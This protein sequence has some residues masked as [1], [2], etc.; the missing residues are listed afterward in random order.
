VAVFLCGLQRAFNDFFC[1]ESCGYCTPCRVGNV[2]LSERLEKIVSIASA[3]VFMQGGTGTLLELALVLEGINKGADKPKPMI[4]LGDFWKP[5]VELVLANRPGK[6][7]RLPW[8]VPASLD[9]WIL[10]AKT[11]EEVPGLIERTK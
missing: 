8:T 2:L 9:R 6:D 11:P 5:V 3:Y 4:F 1:E 10:W 7:P